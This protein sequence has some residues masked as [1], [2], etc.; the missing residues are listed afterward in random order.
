[1]KARKR[2]LLNLLEAL[3]KR[4]KTLA[5]D[6]FVHLRLLQL[7]DRFL[8]LSVTQQERAHFPMERSFV[9]GF[10]Q[11]VLKILERFLR[12]EI[13]LFDAFRFESVRRILF[14]LLRELVELGGRASALHFQEFGEEVIVVGEDAQRAFAGVFRFTIVPLL[15]EMLRQI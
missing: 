15:E 4:N 2:I 12:V 10:L 3:T 9:R 11:T 13:F 8:I 14:V 7:A 5:R 6:S 1:M